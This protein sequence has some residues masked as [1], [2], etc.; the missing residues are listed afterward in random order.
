LERKLTAIFCADV[1]GYSR[2]TGENEEA[3]HRT[4]TSHRKLIDALIEQHHGR[5]VHSAGDSV[6]AEFVSVVNAVHCAV[7]IQTTLEAE[8]ATLPTARRME[9]RIGI[10]LG[11]VIADGV[12]IYGDGVNVAARLESLADPGGIFISGS[13][14]EQLG[15]KLPLGYTDLGEQAVKNIAHPVRVFRV[16]REAGL[17][18][19]TAT[20]AESA[21]K[22]VRRGAF[23]LAGLGVIAVTILLVQHV[24]LKPPHTSASIRPP[25]EPPEGAVARTHPIR[26]IA[27]LPL[28]NFSGDPKQEYFADG[29]TDE[30]TTDL[31]TIS[32]LRVISRG[33]VMRFKGENRP[34]TPEIAKLL[35]VDAVIEGSVL[36]IGDKVRISAQLIDA[37]ADKHLWAKSFE[38]DSRDVLA[39]Q[40]ELAAAIAKEIDVHLTPQ[41]EARL[42]NAPAVNPAAHE[43]YLRGRYFS[44]RP[45]DENLKKAIAAFNEVVR[46]DPNFAPAYSGLSDAYVWAGFNEGVY[47]AAEA[48]PLAKINAEKAVRLDHNSAEAHTSLALF[49]NAYELDWVDSESEFRR[50]LELNPNYAF[51][52][53]Q[54]CATLG[55]EGRLEESVAEG[56]RA[57]ELDPL[58]PEIVSDTVMPLTWAKNYEAALQQAKRATDLDREFFWSAFWMGW[59]YIEA[60]KVEEAI[61]LFRNADAM[62]SPAWV[63]AWLGYAYGVAGDSNGANAVIEEVKRKSVRGDAPAFDL[64]LIDLGLGNRARAL[65]E[66]EQAYAANS[67]WLLFLKMDHVF[68]PLRSEPRFIALLKK[69]HLDK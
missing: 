25:E 33:S 52:H 53:D 63:T 45:S 1:F 17:N 21:R 35:N 60:G 39:L 8:N 41:E 22:Y 37:P 27:A 7:E 50:A 69:V 3:T 6:L 9:F 43:A 14:R 59:V 4:L 56:R 67:P 46:L 49:K 44:G 23:S 57:G 40:D 48:L 19:W 68:D 24:S 11:D 36:R 42:S 18:E 30:L 58:S 32:A 15:N 47:G 65:D 20:K 16:L 26:S 2:L 62:E 29:M 31:A 54:F 55:W 28:D 34:P 38:R 10:N 66:L 61:P 12:E 5:F 64:A 51:A 13:V